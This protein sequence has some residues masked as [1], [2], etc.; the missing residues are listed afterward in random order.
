[1]ERRKKTFR[2]GKVQFSYLPVL[3]EGDVSWQRRRGLK[4]NVAKGGS[5]SLSAGCGSLGWPD[6]SWM[7]LLLLNLVYVNQADSEG[8]VCVCVCVCV[9]VWGWW[10]FHWAETGE[11]D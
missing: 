8:L 1:M 2:E 7:S 3:F 4:I 5:D 10:G 11:T 9:C 6:W